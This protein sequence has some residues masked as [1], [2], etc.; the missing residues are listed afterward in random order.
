MPLLGFCVLWHLYSHSG[1][2]DPAFL[3]PPAAVG[4]ALIDLLKGDEI[5]DNLLI[6]LMRALVV[7]CSAPSRVSG[8]A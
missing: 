7:S 4:R 1:L 5:W 3:P 6:T 2:V 8:S